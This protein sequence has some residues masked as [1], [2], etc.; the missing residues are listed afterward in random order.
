M[1][2]ELQSLD[3]LKEPM[4]LGEVFAESG[5]FPDIKTQ[6]Q[7]VVK[8]MAGKELG[9]SPF[10][11]V[12]GIYMVNGK[13]ALQAGVMSSLIKR[14]RKYD[15]TVDTLDETQCVISFY[16]TT[17]EEHRPLGVSTF[18]FKDAAKAGLVNKENWKNYPKN[19]LFARA[20]SNGARWFCPDV[21]CGWYTA[22]ELQDIE[23]EPVS[24]QK[25]IIEMTAEGVTSGK[26]S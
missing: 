5:M 24:P 11:S 7:G 18:T 22:E 8:I 6:A 10:Q 20:L 26:E 15:Y 12:S 21:I 23:S 2:Q 3:I 25:H 17:K 19:M 14:S 4:A 9:L 1:T 16:D 13:L